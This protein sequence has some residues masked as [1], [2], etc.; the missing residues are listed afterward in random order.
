MAENFVYGEVYE[1]PVV[2]LLGIL[3]VQLN[4]LIA[5]GD[6]ISVVLQAFGGLLFEL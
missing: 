5:L 1:V 6:S 2:G 3:Q 4:N